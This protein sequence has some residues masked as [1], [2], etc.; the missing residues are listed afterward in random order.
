MMDTE[1]ARMQWGRRN[2]RSALNNATAAE[3]T[4]HLG[5]FIFLRL[6]QNLQQ[7]QMLP[8]KGY[9]LYYF[10]NYYCY[11]YYCHRASRYLRQKWFPTWF[12]ATPTWRNKI[13]RGPC[14]SVAGQTTRR[15][16]DS[17]APSYR[18]LTRHIAHRQ[19]YVY[20]HEAQSEYNNTRKN[21]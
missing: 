5:Y 7:L 16:P 2:A 10:Y 4:L 13:P 18:G 11:F 9:N 17:I 19:R 21:S 8:L 1:P 6:L 20:P 3:N 14:T 15:S 12:Y